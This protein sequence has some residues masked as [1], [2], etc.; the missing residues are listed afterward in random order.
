MLIGD[1]ISIL[2]SDPFVDVISNLN[3]TI[4]GSPVINKVNNEIGSGVVIKSNQYFLLDKQ[5]V[6]SKMQIKGTFGFWLRAPL[7]NPSNAMP[8]LGI[9]TNGTISGSS[10]PISGMI[11]FY[12]I[13][14]EEGQIYFRI[15]MHASESDIRIFYYGPIEPFQLKH[16][17][18][19]YNLNEG[20]ISLY[21]DGAIV[22]LLR[23][24]SGS[25]SGAIPIKIFH[26]ASHR[27]LFN[28]FSSEPL[29]LVRSGGFE[30]SDVLIFSDY[31]S[32]IS[33]IAVII[34]DGGLNFAL[35]KTGTQQGSLPSMS[36]PAISSSFKRGRIND[37]VS[38]A[39]GVLAGTEDGNILLGV[40]KFW[41]KKI[42]FGNPEEVNKVIFSK[43]SS[44]FKADINDGG[45][46]DVRGANFQIL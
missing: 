6:F 24:S 28:K 21:S 16:F 44:N 7:I 22:D 15:S 1:N 17:I 36:L 42:S 5:D 13:S 11:Y 18:F 27:L 14:N 26:S 2:C 46:L 12:L 3:L 4:D 35:R 40:E 30:I 10:V 23:E 45:F 32:E 19:S 8:I 31:V 29:S 41:Q 25:S 37:S 9:G 20:L 34:N 43:T 33:D 39:F 38:T